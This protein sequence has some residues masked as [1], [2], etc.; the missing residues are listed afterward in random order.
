[1]AHAEICPVCSG[2]GCTDDGIEPRITVDCHGCNGKGWVEVGNDNIPVPYP[3]PA[4]TPAI[5]PE[6]PLVTWT[7]SHDRGL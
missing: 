7:Y 4:P 5:G 1:M 6:W 2:T 3:V